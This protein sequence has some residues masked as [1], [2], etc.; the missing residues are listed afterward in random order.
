MYIRDWI[1]HI[2]NLFFQIQYNYYYKIFPKIK[3]NI[4]F[5]KWE[6]NNIGF[7]N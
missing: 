6:Y 2:N 7:K 4:I 3:K 1:H 5:L